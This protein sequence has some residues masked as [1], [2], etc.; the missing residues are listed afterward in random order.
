MQKTGQQCLK[1]KTPTHHNTTTHSAKRLTSILSLPL[2]VSVEPRGSIVPLLL[3]ASTVDRAMSVTKHPHH[4]PTQQQSASRKGSR[5]P[6]AFRICRSS[7]DKRIVLSL[8]TPSGHLGQRGKAHN[9]CTHSSRV[10]T[11]AVLLAA[12]YPIFRGSVT[13]YPY[14][15]PVCR[16]KPVRHSASRIPHPA[17]RVPRPMT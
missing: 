1:Q 9:C 10:Q 3:V 6:L 13:I 15:G 11:T 8:N 17:S 5:H 7:S 14:G 16:M 2:A 4:I 12:L